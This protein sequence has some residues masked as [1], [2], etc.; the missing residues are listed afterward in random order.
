MNRSMG[1][2]R[3][4]RIS[5]EVELDPADQVE[6]GGGTGGD[7]APRRRAAPFRWTPG[8]APSWSD[9]PNGRA[10]P[11][12]RTGV[13]EWWP[14]AMPDGFELEVS[15]KWIDGEPLHYARPTTPLHPRS[16]LRQRMQWVAHEW[17]HGVPPLLGRAWSEDDLRAAWQAQPWWA[18]HPAH[19]ERGWFA[20][21]ERRQQ[22]VRAW[23]EDNVERARGKWVTA[24]QVHRW[25]CRWGVNPIGD[26]LDVGEHPDFVY[27]EQ[28]A[29]ALLLAGYEPGRC[30]GDGWLWQIKW[31]AAQRQYRSEM[32][33]KHRRY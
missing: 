11:S 2:L 5:G 3:A 23:V 31:P 17:R 19:P 30:R 13:L 12:R 15:R 22:R 8:P 18:Y 16:S 20:L 21:D 32:R 4:P 26:A 6:V 33:R 28:M 25:A 9:G 14:G 24:S 27:F 29:A 1:A 10:F 7:G